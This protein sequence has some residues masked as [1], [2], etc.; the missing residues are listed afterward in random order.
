MLNEAVR[1]GLQFLSAV[2]S[3]AGLDEAIA[4][5]HDV[6]RSLDM[7]R[8]AMSGCVWSA[9]AADEIG[10]SFESVSGALDLL[11]AKF[12]DGWVA[13]R[14]WLVLHHS[15][16][17]W[18]EQV[19]PEKRL[20]EP[21]PACGCEGVGEKRFVHPTFPEI[22]RRMWICVRCGGVADLP[23]DID[24]IAIH[25]PDC[26]RPGDVAPITLEVLARPSDAASVVALPYFGGFGADVVKATMPE[27]P[28][29]CRPDG[30]GKTRIH[31]DICFAKD[32]PGGLYSLVIVGAVAFTPF[33]GARYITVDP[34][35]HEVK[36]A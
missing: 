13:A 10:Q 9:E 29:A 33:L 4:A 25:A 17:H 20:G 22:D 3:V 27:K 19:G 1:H 6:R 32:C 2:T 35:R 7:L 11:S 12:C 28:A 15:Y 34:D 18:L 21:C 16:S 30:V 5:A 23:A 14:Q 26:V 31:F 36:L 8:Q 24:Q